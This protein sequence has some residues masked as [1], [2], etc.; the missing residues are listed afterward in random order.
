MAVQAEATSYITGCLCL[1]WP[2][3]E[4]LMNRLG[5]CLSDGLLLRVIAD[6]E[7]YTVQAK[8]VEEPLNSAILI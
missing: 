6:V 5:R 4:F 7:C 2:F 3:L 8:C 1:R